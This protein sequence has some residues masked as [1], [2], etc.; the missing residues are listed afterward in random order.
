MRKPGS[1]EY[2]VRLSFNS[3]ELRMKWVATPEHQ[4]AWPALSG[5]S[6]KTN[7]AGFGVVHPLK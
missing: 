5:L 4:K 2:T 3:E 6:A 7:Y 1:S